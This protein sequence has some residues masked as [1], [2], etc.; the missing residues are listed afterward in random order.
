MAPALSDW[1]AFGGHPEKSTLF[2]SYGTKKASNDDAFFVLSIVPNDLTQKK[3][4][5]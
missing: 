2:K 5:G 1:Q 4:S 3:D